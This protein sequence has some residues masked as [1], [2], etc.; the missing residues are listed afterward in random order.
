MNKKGFIQIGEKRKRMKN[1]GK[2][3]YLSRLRLLRDDFLESF[4]SRE[5]D[6]DLDFEE[7]WRFDFFSGGGE[8][9]GMGFDDS[10]S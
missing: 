9:E 4:L 10:A 7:E 3:R 5:R 6:L 1:K 2:C 8:E